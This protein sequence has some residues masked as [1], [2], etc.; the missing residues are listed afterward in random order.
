[1]GRGRFP[2]VGL[3]V[4]VF[5]L[6]DLKVKVGAVV[7]DHAGIPASNGK[8]VFKEAAL[9]VIGF[10]G[11]DGERTVNIMELKRWVPNETGSVLKAALF[12]RRVENPGIDKA[13]EDII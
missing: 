1:M 7:I 6:F 2:L 5:G 8:T 4:V 3:L 13:R 11:D 9:D 12:G 10:L